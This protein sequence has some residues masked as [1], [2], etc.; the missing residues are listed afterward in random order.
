MAFVGK[1]AEETVQQFNAEI[2]FF[3]SSSLSED[4]C[5]SDYSEEET[6]L[7]QTMSQQSQKTVFLCDSAKIGRVAAHH[8]FSPDEIDAIVTDQ[9]LSEELLSKLS[10]TLHKEGNGAYLYEK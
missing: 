2:F 4:G 6:A 9:P 10:M 1:R 3:S 8:A 7:R 5:V